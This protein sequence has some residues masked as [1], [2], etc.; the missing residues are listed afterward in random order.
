MH[1]LRF[2]AL[3]VLIM[4][5]SSTVAAC[6]PA[7]EPDIQLSSDHIDLGTV[8]NGQV[9]EFSVDVRNT[10]TA[11][12]IIEAVTTSCGCTSASVSP[13]TI[14]PGQT[15]ALHVTYDSGAHGPEFSGEA[16]RQVFIASNDPDEREVIFDLAVNVIP[17]EGGS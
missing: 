12:L 9:E 10:G 3:F 14:Q 13:E 4:L 5:I 15:G 2:A 6:G 17:E 11:P 8:N 16:E 1:R 7:G